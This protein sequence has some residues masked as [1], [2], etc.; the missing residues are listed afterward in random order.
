[1]STVKNFVLLTLLSSL[2][3]ACDPVG[4][5]AHNESVIKE[6][7]PNCLKA[8]NNDEKYCRESAEKL[9]ITREDV[10]PL[11]NQSKTIHCT[12]N[13]GKAPFSGRPTSSTTCY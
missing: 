1:M 7:Y 6:Y 12:T 5:R 9:L 10:K 8:Y 2:V 13:Y 4:I 11:M 3:V